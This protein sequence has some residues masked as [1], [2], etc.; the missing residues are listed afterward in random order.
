MFV[1]DLPVVDRIGCIIPIAK[2]AGGTSVSSFRPICLLTTVYKLFSILV[3]QKVRDRVKEYVSWTQ[4]GF[5]RG[6]SCGNNLWILRRVAERAIEFNVPIYCAL[7]DYKGAFDA[8]NRTTLGRILALFLS[9][10][11]VRRVLTLYFDAKAMVRIDGAVGPL[12]DLLRGV[13][14]GCP[15]SPNFFTVALAYVSWT[16]CLAFKGIKLVKLHLSSLEY[17]DDQLLFTLTPHGLQEMLTFLADTAEPFGLRLAPHKCE[18]ICFHRPGTVNKGT[19]PRVNVGDKIL[20]WKSTVVYLG[21][22]FS[23]DGN[24]LSALKHRICCAESIVTRLNDRVF[25]RRTVSDRLKGK[26]VT[27]AVFASL[28]YGL[29]HCAFGKREHRCLDGYFLRLAKRIMHLRH[30]HHLSYMEAEE[31][32]GVQRPSLHLRKERLRWTGHVLR[33]D[34]TAVLYE[35]LYFVPE[36]GARRRG[37]P[38]RRFYDTV[39]EDLAERKIEI[40]ARDQIRFWQALSEKAA[41]RAEWRTVVVCG[42]ARMD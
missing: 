32:L 29:E 40:N 34:D 7:V 20:Q 23:E 41:D 31:R 5:I 28:L 3:F 30:D 38:R 13:R 10:S 19:L 9:P 35:V 2:K 15:A 26:F 21:S 27:S 39:K 16:F 33:S 14:Q 42:D 11:M 12:F 18:L 22:T 8:L 36:G 4:S 25:C 17:A 1:S 6:R 37:R 24:T